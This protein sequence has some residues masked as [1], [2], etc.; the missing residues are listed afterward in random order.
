MMQLLSYGHFGDD[1]DDDDDDFPNPNH[2]FHVHHFHNIKHARSE[3]L[4]GPRLAEISSGPCEVGCSSIE[5]GTC[6]DV[7]HGKQAFVY[8]FPIFFGFQMGYH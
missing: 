2:H 4:L 5:T 1:D 6:C 7:S 3:R 8:M